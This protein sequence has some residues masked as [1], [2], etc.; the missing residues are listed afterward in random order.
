[1]WLEYQMIMEDKEDKESIF[2]KVLITTSGLGERLGDLT[3]FTNKSLIRVGKKPALSYI[4][5]SYPV[6][7]EFVITL[8]WFKQ[9]VTEF[10]SI[11]YPDRKFH[12]VD[13]VPFEGN[14]SSLAY[15][16]LQAKQHLQE[17]FIFHACDTIVPYQRY[18]NANWMLGS[19]K[20]DSSHYVTFDTSNENVIK[21]YPKGELASRYSYCGVCGI[22]DFNTFFETLENKVLQND[23]QASDVAGLEGLASV[24]SVLT[25]RWLD[26]GNVDGLMLARG[27][28]NDA[29]E[30]LDKV[31]ESIF[32]FDNAVIKF[33]ADKKICSDRVS[34]AKILG[35]LVPK[36]IASG[37]N[38]YKYDF[39]P[40]DVLSRDCSVERFAA[41]LEHL[42][43]NLWIPA[44]R[45]IQEAC[46]S[47]YKDKTSSR[48]VDFLKL[49]GMTDKKET[50]NGLEVLSA[51]ELL[52]G[53]DWNIITDGKAGGFHGD[54]IL[55]NIIYNDGQFCLIDWRQNFAG[56]IDIGDQYYDLAKLN[57]NLIFNHDIINN[58]HFQIQNGKVDLLRSHRL[59]ECQEELF[60]WI[61]V[62]ALNLWKVKVLTSIV[63]LNMAPLHHYPLNKFLYTLGRYSLQRIINDDVKSIN[64]T[65]EQGVD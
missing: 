22:V 1:M 61:E 42:E 45:N 55:D 36:V 64:R 40:G 50:I 33:F 12:F 43:N 2:H 11:Q 46:R 29:F 37:E 16:I 44:D 26:I 7:T 14:G 56:M 20:R 47:F 28:I 65:D 4:I 9:H 32:I 35:T 3:K 19:R 51:E 57:H 23:K 34:R 52:N 39:F 10:L 59:M 6:D 17:P 48:L 8:G 53:L 27:E 63:W 18:P 30:I 5:E 38:F 24:R 60:K 21:I 49:T 58:N 41:L 25:D 31:D 62:K 54:L 13:V 15:S